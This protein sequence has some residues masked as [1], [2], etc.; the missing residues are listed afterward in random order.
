M[1]LILHNNC[2]IEMEFRNIISGAIMFFILRCKNTVFD[3]K[4]LKF[5]NNQV[6]SRNKKYYFINND[7]RVYFIL[8]SETL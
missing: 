7:V 5:S 6:Q 3:I 1:N 2:I 4:T 8:I